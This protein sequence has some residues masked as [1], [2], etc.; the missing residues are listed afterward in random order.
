MAPAGTASQAAEEPYQENEQ[1]E[2]TY[3][4][5]TPQEV[6]LAAAGLTEAERQEYA[7]LCK[8]WT[9]ASLKQQNNPEVTVL[10]FMNVA[11]ITRYTE[12][13]NKAANH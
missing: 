10:E 12:L 2:S 1:E 9:E 6:E 13:A 4:D 11:E 3:E 7:E 5:P 8:K